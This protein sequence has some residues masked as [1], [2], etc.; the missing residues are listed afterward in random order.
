[1][2]VDPPPIFVFDAF[3]TL[4]DVHSGMRENAGAI[5][6]NAQRFSEIWR[7]KQLEYTWIYAGIG[8]GA[9]APDFRTIT[10]NSLQ[11]ALAATG[12][13]QTLAPRLRESYRR[14][15]A[16]PE[17]AASLRSAKARG[18]RLAILSNADPD[19]LDELVCHAELGDVFDFV[20]SVRGTGTYKPA[21]SVY[22]LA[23]DA[24]QCAPSSITFVSSNRWDCAG[25]KA[26]GLTTLWVNRTNT[27]PEYDDLAVD[28]VVSNL[29]DGALK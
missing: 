20:L 11:Y 26:F 10:E 24:F 1:M 15:A 23:T 6:P 18:A 9:S 19:M 7:G 4:F 2:Q 29:A 28:R 12:L 22:R 14:L 17:V 3:G 25:A 16:F 27:P 8:S 21:A 5:G 13:A